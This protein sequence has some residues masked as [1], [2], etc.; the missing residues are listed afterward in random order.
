MR[1]KKPE[2][3]KKSQLRLF[4]FVCVRVTSP[5]RVP[6]SSHAKAKTDPLPVGPEQDGER[7]PMF[8]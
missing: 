4:Q 8:V 3:K 5:R 7:N 6:F 2:R 1:E